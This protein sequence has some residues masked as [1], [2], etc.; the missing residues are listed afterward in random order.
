MQAQLQDRERNESTRELRDRTVIENLPLVRA[1][2][3]RVHE[4]LPLYVELDDLVHAGVLGLFDAVEKYDAAK[5]VSFQAYAK[6]RIKGAML[7]SL[8]QLDWASRDLRKH[9]RNAEEATR[10]LA[11]RFGRAP[12][13]DEVAKEMGISVDRW[14][15]ISMELSK[16]GLVQPTN[17]RDSERERDSIAEFPATPEL[18][19]DSMCEQRQLRSTLGRAMAVLPARYQKVVHLY[20]VG[21]LTMKEIGDVLGVNESRV[22]QIHKSALRRMAAALE[23]EGIHSAN[24][25]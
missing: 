23:S 1:I 9:Q 18:R 8:R 13:A 10:E 20:Y 16:V 17:S 24:A 22:S 3:I 25:L 11:V 15:R 4:N 21:D 14:R 6:H 2:A 7:D 5:N 12:G 19:P